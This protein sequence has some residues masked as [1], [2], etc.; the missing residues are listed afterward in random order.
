MQ[1]TVLLKPHAQKTKVPRYITFPTASLVF[2]KALSGS[3]RVVWPLLAG[4]QDAH[5]MPAG[6]SHTPTIEDREGQC[7]GKG[8]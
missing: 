8:T 7:G 1:G 3:V 4:I 6:D 5:P 2:D